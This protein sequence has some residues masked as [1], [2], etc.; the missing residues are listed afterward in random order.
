MRALSPLRQRCES[1]PADKEAYIAAQPRSGTKIPALR[2]P[3]RFE[4]MPAIQGRSP[5]PMLDNTNMREPIP[6]DA[7]PN[8]LDKSEMVMGYTEESPN[9][10]AQALATTP[11]EPVTKTLILKFL[12]K[13]EAI[14]PEPI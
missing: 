12:H 11:P 8:P 10:V 6:E 14:R 4:E 1:N 2:V 13:R 9:P 7:E 3:N 5:P